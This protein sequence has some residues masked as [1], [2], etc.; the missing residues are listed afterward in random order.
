MKKLAIAL[1]L[2][3]AGALAFA[4]NEQWQEGWF[5]GIGT[6]AT[7]TDLK[8][9]NG[10]W[11]DKIT[12]DTATIENDA[13]VLD[14]DDGDEALFTVTTAS[15]N[16]KTAQKIKVKGVFTPITASELPTDDEMKTKAAQVGFAVVSA[17]SESTTTYSYYAWVGKGDSDTTGWVSLGTCASATATTDLTITLAYWTDSVK[18][19]FAIKN[20]ETALAT[21]EKNLAGD[22]LTAAKAN[23]KVASVACTGSGTLNSLSGDAQIAVA[24][25]GE[26]NYGTLAEAVTAAGSTETSVKLLADVKGDATIP[27]E[28][29]ITLDENG[30][31]AS[32][33]VNNGTVTFTLTEDESGKGNATIT[34][35]IASNGGT[36]AATPTDSSKE[37][38]VGTPAD[39]KVTITVQ[40]KKAILDEV[41]FENVSLT[42]DETAFRKFMTD[43]KIEAYTGA[44]STAD[45]I[46]SALEEKG[47]NTLAKWQSYALGIAPSTK[48][49]TGYATDTDSEAITIALAP[50]DEDVAI[51]SSGDFNIT[52][53]CGEKT[54]TSPS[55]IKVPLA[56]G[57]Y[58]VKIVFT[59]PTASE[60][61]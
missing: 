58:P 47:D 44:N 40:T 24:Q 48:L 33:V 34:R 7:V 5:N 20:G 38:V 39:G 57:R 9:T 23:F 60:N 28:A 11:N 17:T 19:T 49:A 31:S 18:A 43:N 21:V 27:A 46:K 4:D 37:C 45:A 41:K 59:A 14:L 2:A 26:Q 10:S 53:K 35:T 16:T 8:P 61:E 55:E 3:C 51:T 1:S 29:K 36:L 56:T 15:E 13:L 52:Y 30:K 25:I 12:A 22:A 32:S 54:A 6:G 50:V 42:K